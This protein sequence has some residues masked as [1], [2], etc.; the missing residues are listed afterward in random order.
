MC[1][2][3]KEGKQIEEIRRIFDSKASGGKIPDNN[4]NG[5]RAKKQ[6]DLFKGESR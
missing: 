2:S 3:L 5:R 4:G 6:G 1:G